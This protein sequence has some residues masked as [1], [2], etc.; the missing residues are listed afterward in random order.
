MLLCRYN[1]GSRPWPSGI[2]VE[3]F[4]KGDLLDVVCVTSF[5][6]CM[7]LMMV[8]VPVVVVVVVVVVVEVVCV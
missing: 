3:G 5:L 2:R 4:Q 6:A 7:L 8:P 1:E